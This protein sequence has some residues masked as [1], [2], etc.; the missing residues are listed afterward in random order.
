MLR[1]YINEAEAVYYEKLFQDTK[2]S[3][4]NMWK[5]LGVI[6]NPNKKKRTCHINKLLCDGKFI[7]D[8]KHIYDSMNTYFCKIG[9]HL[10]QLM[11]N[12]GT[13]YNRYF[14][15]RVNSTFFLTPVNENELLKEIKRLN[16]RKSSGADKLKHIS[17]LNTALKM[18]HTYTYSRVTHQYFSFSVMK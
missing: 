16:P 2:S 14:S 18:N 4:Y 10:Q 8:N 3:S 9:S 15:N 5:H 1:R 12:C 7:T 6:I 11:P 13:E 17:V